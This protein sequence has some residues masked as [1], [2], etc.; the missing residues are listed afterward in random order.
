MKEITLYKVT[1]LFEV[2]L[3]AVSAPDA[4]NKAKERLEDQVGHLSWTTSDRTVLV[5]DEEE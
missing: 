3:Q 4:I 1:T 5:E 2:E